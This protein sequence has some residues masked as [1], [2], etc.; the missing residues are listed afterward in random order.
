VRIISRA[1]PSAAPWYE[2][3]HVRPA[4][5]DLA[6]RDALHVELADVYA[7]AHRHPEA[8]HHFLEHRKLDEFSEVQLARAGGRLVAWFGVNGFE[9]DGHRIETF[10]DAVV[11]PGFQHRGITRAL[12][13]RLYRRIAVR[14][15]RTPSVVAILVTNPLVAH[16]VESHLRSG[17]ARYPAMTRSGQRPVWL[18]GLAEGVARRLHPAAPFDAR[19]GVLHGFLP[20]WHLAPAACPDPDV[21]RYF[22]EHLTPGSAVLMLVP[23][24]R[25]MVLAHVGVWAAK[26]A[27]TARE[28]VRSAG[29]DRR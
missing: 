22:A 20:A 18:D 21:E 26:A 29:R 6:A 8:R 9:L 27:Q 10:D 15:W 14:C 11:D 16:A 5:L 7:A 28:R 12:T 25:R 17:S 3:D 4:D 2:L 13:L 1:T 19:T 24:D 23:V